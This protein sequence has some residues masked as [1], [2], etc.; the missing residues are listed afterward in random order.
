MKELKYEITRIKYEITV[1]PTKKLPGSL[2]GFSIKNYR[3]CHKTFVNLFKQKRLAKMWIVINNEKER[4]GEIW[5]NEEEGKWN[6]YID[7]QED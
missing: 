7:E 2:K 3:K 1:E 5:F 6:Y 4:I